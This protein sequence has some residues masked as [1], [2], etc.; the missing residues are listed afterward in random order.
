MMEKAVPILTLAKW[1]PVFW[2]LGLCV[3]F[4]VVLML[5]DYIKTRKRKG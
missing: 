3:G 5:L 4:F 1:V 2:I